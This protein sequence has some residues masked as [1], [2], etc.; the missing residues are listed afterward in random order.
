[1]AG[2]RVLENFIGGEWVE[3]RGERAREVVSPVTGERLAEAPEASAEEISRAARA[4]REAQPRW[5]ALSAWERA[6]VC[7]AVADLLEERKEELARQLSLEQGKP[8]RSEAIPDIEETAENFRVAAEDVKRLETAVIPS[9]DANKRIFTFREPNG[10]YACIT[11]WNFPTVIPSE[12]IAPAIAAG[13]AVVA[14]P[15]EWTPI[16]MA[17]LVQT[18]ADAG[19]P[20]GVVNLVYGA[21]EVGER[22]V[23]DPAVDCVAFVGSHQTAERIVRSAG[24]RRTLIEASGNGPVIVC[25]DADLRRAAKGAVFGGFYCSGQ[26]CCATERVLVDRSVH[27]DFLRAVVEEARSWKLG[28]P[29]E[30]DTLVGPMNN[31]PTAAKMDRHLEDAVGKGA[32]V[33]LGGGR[34]EG[35]PTSL[36]YRPTVLDNVGTDTLINRDETF[37][38]IVPLIPVS[39]DEEALAVANDSH[40]GLQ[41]A[42]YTSSL[43]RAFAYL[44]N[45]RV[46][47]VVIN[48]STDYWE[49][50]EPF[51]GAAGTR[52]GWGRVGGRYSL[53]EM[54][55]LKTVVLDFGSLEG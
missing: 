44:R 32:S 11:P 48:D 1:M 23:T 8:Y 45:L 25:A 31:E 26:V 27:E 29:F 18:M 33:V 28:D 14:K 38:P 30:E 54:T 40:L 3:A 2:V 13:N 21:G 7:H 47:N 37:G 9:Q 39:G 46:G 4:A 6:E 51:G 42:V 10:V 17:N 34:E 36:Y 41:A 24:L 16:S 15:S 49:A 53:L 22:L 20:G 12:L 43:R 50:L 52:T 55:D 5:A 35:R 19:L